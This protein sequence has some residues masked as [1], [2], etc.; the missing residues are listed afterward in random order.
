MRIIDIHTH[1]GF[2]INF[3]T[4]T[5]GEIKEFANKVV[6]HSTVGFCPTLATDS[7]QNIQKQLEVFNAFKQNQ[8]TGAL[9][10]GVHLECIFL[11]PQKAGIHNIEQFL[12]PTVENFKKIVGEFQNIIK[13]VTLAPEL[14]KNLE[15]TK[16]LTS[17]GIKV[18]A[19]HTMANEIHQGISGTTHHFNAMPALSHHKKNITLEALI[20]E[21]VFSEIVA[22]GRHVNKLMLELFFKIKNPEKIILIS[23]S[24]PIAHSNLEEFNFCGQTIFKN[25]ESKN[26]TLAGSIHFVEDII[27]M[28]VEN[29]ILTEKTAKK[30]VWEN[31]IAHLNVSDI[32]I[33][34]MKKIKKEQK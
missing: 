30:I 11:N 13:I 21:N 16:Y 2:G 14:D 29:K 22:D 32:D 26:G 12:E 3:N 19:G 5:L 33:E 1:G 31:P 6:C 17:N 24:L 4:C 23:D 27:N 34:K 25:G 7:A 10:L 28:L 20:Y 9:M 18:H 15:L 8:K